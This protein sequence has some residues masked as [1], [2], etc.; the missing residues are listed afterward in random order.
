MSIQDNEGARSQTL[1]S[2][3]SYDLG[4]CHSLNHA[5]HVRSLNDWVSRMVEF[6]R[7]QHKKGEKGDL[8]LGLGNE[9]FLAAV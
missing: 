9:E 7:V 8:V 1:H 3:F 5:E 6:D 2:G 4:I